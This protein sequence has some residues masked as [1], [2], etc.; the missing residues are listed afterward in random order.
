MADQNLDERFEEI[1]NKFLAD[2]GSVDC[3]ALAYRDGLRVAVDS[4]N[5]AISASVEMDGEG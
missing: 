2:M 5:A 1:T 4:I 3:T